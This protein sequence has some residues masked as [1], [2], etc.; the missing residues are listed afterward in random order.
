MRL[1][2]L[3]FLYFVVVM[4]QLMWITCMSREFTSRY[5]MNEINHFKVFTLC[6]GDLAAD[7]NI[8]KY[9]TN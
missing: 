5:H 8:F 3:K 6:S 2:I 4:W 7:V 9:R 1:I